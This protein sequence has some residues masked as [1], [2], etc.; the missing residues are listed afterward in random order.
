[1]KK[2]IFAFITLIAMTLS[3]GCT[4]SSPESGTGNGT[5]SVSESAP[6]SVS[7]AV[8]SSEMISEPTNAPVETSMQSSSAASEP[9][10]APEG[11]S[12]EVN[13]PFFK[14]EDKNSG[15]VVYMLGSMHIGKEG[16][17]Y[18]D[19]MYKALDECDTLAVEV[20]IQALENDLSASMEATMILLCER[21]K[22]VRDYLG[23]DY[24]PIM[25]KFREKGL[26]NRLYES[27]IPA[28]WSSLWTSAAAVES[29]FDVNAGTDRLLL[30]YAKEHGKAVE[31]IESAKEQY[32]MEAD[33]SA[34]MQTYTLKTATELSAEE[35][36]EQLDTLYDAWKSGDINTLRSL[37][38]DEGS[39]SESE[40]L[41]EELEADYEKYYAAMYT[42]RQKKM[43]DYI[44][45]KLKTGGKTFV[46]VGALHYAAPP[47]ILDILAE[48]GYTVETLQ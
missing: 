19:K 47:S 17:A 3:A 42:D 33:N 21:G 7:A 18:P 46:V 41:P 25:Q 13:P 36:K 9:M 23:D 6:T 22:T 45:N 11:E 10:S 14:V 37:V 15:A 28:L 20:D 27:Y 29:G 12:F 8:S 39:D 16:A 44:Q 43:A 38:E 40:V 24:E 35:T 31:E 30:T 2:R 26:Y 4:G 34:E 5:A 32:Q 48:N 1:M